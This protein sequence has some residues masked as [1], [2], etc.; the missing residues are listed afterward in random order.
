MCGDGW[1]ICL[2]ILGG[3]MGNLNLMYGQFECMSNLTVWVVFEFRKKNNYLN[4]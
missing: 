2:D 1:F 4:E 3:F